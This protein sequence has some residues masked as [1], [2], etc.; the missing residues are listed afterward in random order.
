M[1][2]AIQFIME[3][4]QVTWDVAIELYWDEIESYMFLKSEECKGK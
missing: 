2:D 1:D 4:Y 3:L